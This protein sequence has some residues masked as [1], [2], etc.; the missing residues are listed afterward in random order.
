MDIKNLECFVEIVNSEYNLSVAS[1]KLHLSQ[2]ALSYMIKNFEMEENTLLFERYRGRLKSLTPSGEVFYKNAVLIL[3][4]YQ[5]MLDEIRE[6]SVH[7]KGKIKIGIPPLVL[8]VS[9]AHIMPTLILDNPDISFD[10]IEMGAYE[11]R[12]SLLAKNLDFAVLLQPTDVNAS[13]VNEHV[14]MQSELSAFMNADN[15][16]AKNEK[17]SWDQLSSQ[18]LAIFDNTFMIHHQLLKRFKSESIRPKISIMSACW[19]YLFLAAKNTGLITILPSPISKVFKMDGMVE[20]PFENPIPWRTVLCQIK[21]DRYSH[22][23]K[24]VLEQIISYFNNKPE[25]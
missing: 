17:L 6:V 23:E 21:K 3:K 19:D 22:L 16:L 7:Y 9:L 25:L 12:K 10:I 15:P 4:S 13:I 2:P 14:L 18:P 8:G 20:V 24:H 1:K 5:S 11:L